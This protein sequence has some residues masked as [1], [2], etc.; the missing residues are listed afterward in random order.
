MKKLIT[1]AAILFV[2]AISGCCDSGNNQPSSGEGTDTYSPAEDTFVPG[3]TW[4]DPESGLT[5]QNIIYW[6]TMS[7]SEADEYCGDITLN[8]GGWHLPTIG[9][10]RSLIRDCPA[11]EAGGDCLVWEGD[12]LARECSLTSC[13]GCSFKEGNGEDGLYWPPEL[14]GPCCDY[15]SSADYE[16]AADTA[17]YVNFALASVEPALDGLD[18]NV[19]CVR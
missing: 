7:W 3:G 1:G 13:N 14:K 5:W 15:W 8:G 17:W 18:K 2:A 16:S 6:Q 10:L 12:C 4:T 11:T 9:E 19:R